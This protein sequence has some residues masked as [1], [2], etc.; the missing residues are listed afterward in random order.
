MLRLGVVGILARE[1]VKFWL[2]MLICPLFVL[3]V[4]TAALFAI[5]ELTALFALAWRFEPTMVV[6]LLV[7]MLILLAIR[8]E[9]IDWVCWAGVDALE[10]QCQFY[11]CVEAIGA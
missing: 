6:V 7:L 8:L 5:I 10:R 3:S 9:A 4:L 1:D 2:F 11:P